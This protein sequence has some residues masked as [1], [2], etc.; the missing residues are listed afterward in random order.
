MAIEGILTTEQLG[1]HKREETLAK[2]AVREQNHATNIYT[3]MSS[4]IQ[5]KGN[6]LSQN[7]VTLAVKIF[8][9]GTTAFSKF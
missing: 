7:A 9:G 8:E 5:A 1:R 3:T 2:V 4:G 6:M